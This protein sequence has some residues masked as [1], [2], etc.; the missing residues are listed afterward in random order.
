MNLRLVGVAVA[1]SRACR[2]LLSF[3]REKECAESTRCHRAVTVYRVYFAVTVSAYFAE[4]HLLSN[5]GGQLTYHPPLLYMAAVM[6]FRP[7]KWQAFETPLAK[8]EKK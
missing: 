5:P 3:L 6:L 8:G 2:L 1:S 4:R 7:K